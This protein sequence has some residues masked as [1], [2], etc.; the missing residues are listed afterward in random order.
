[1]LCQAVG[2]WKEVTRVLSPWYHVLIGKLW[3]RLGKHVLIKIIPP[4]PGKTPALTTMALAAELPGPVARNYGVTCDDPLLAIHS[5]VISG[6][7]S[8]RIGGLVL[9]DGKFPS[10]TG[11]PVRKF[12]DY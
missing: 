4:Y 1:M 9:S 7:A 3:Y 12:W 11:L 8:M 6:R 2:I 5:A 10:K